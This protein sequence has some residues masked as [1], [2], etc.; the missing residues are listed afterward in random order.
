[1][2][3]GDRARVGGALAGHAH[4]AGNVAEVVE[5]EKELL[6]VV[7]DLLHARGQQLEPLLK[8]AHDGVPGK[9]GVGKVQVGARLR[10]V[11]GLHKQDDVRHGGLAAGVAQ[12]GRVRVC[13]CVKGRVV[14]RERAGSGAPLGVWGAGSG[15]DRMVGGPHA[16]SASPPLPP[17]CPGPPARALCRHGLHPLSSC[18]GRLGGRGARASWRSGREGGGAGARGRQPHSGQGRGAAAGEGHW[19]PCAGGAWG[20]GRAAAGCKLSAHL[21][22]WWDVA[23]CK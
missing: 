11:A 18:A 3:G 4:H 5:V 7:G 15:Q 12:A 21:L 6:H 9:G 13:V 8:Q 2:G 19:T 16:R 10:V 22:T 20:E 17:L 1:M 14:T 23:L